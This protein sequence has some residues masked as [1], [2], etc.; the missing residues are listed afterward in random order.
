M[1][2]IQQILENHGTPKTARAQ[3]VSL[4]NPLRLSVRHFPTLIESAGNKK[5]SQKKCHVHS[6]NMLGTRSRK[7]T[8]YECKDCGKALYLDPCFKDYHYKK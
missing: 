5:P 1:R 7:D 3:N 4:N 2:L 6:N 8:R